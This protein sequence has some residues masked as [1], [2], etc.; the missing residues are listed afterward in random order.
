VGWTLDRDESA[1]GVAAIGVFIAAAF[2]L[3]AH[4]DITSSRDLYIQRNQLAGLIRDM[5]AL[6]WL[7]EH[8]IDIP[9]WITEQLD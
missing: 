2:F 8:D 5:D 1:L 9:E 3:A 4:D 7:D 6:T